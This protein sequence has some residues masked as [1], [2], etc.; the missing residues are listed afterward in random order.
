MNWTDTTFSAVRHL[1]Y[2]SRIFSVLVCGRNWI[3]FMHGWFYQF[4]LIAQKILKCSLVIQ[5][6]SHDLQRGVTRDQVGLFQHNLWNLLVFKRST[7]LFTQSLASRLLDLPWLWLAQVLW[8]RKVSIGC[9]L[10]PL[11]ATVS[12]DCSCRWHFGNG[13]SLWSRR[14]CE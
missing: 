13:W 12:R 11:A 7:V 9:E 3:L 14:L 2:Y 8:N 5:P 1:N 6:Y 10:E 4:H